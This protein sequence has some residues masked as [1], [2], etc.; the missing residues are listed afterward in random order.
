MKNIQKEFKIKKC[1]KVIS[2]PIGDQI[3]EVDIT[4]F[5]PIIDHPH[6]Q[7]LKHISQLTASNVVYPEAEHKRFSHS[8]AAME[9]TRQRVNL[10]KEHKMIN[11]DDAQN[12]NI[13][14]LTHDVGH[15]PLSHIMDRIS[16]TCNHDQNGRMK[17]QEMKSEIEACNGS[18]KKVTDLFDKKD[19]LYQAVMH[20]PLGTDKFSYLSQDAEHCVS[21]GRPNI[22]KLSQYIYWYN[23]ELIVDPK[24]VGLAMDLQR[25][26]IMMYREVYFRK[27]AT[28]ANR[29]LEKMILIL[30]KDGLDE[31]TLWEM[32]DSN[33]EAML[34]K[35]KNKRV[36]K[37]HGLWQNR[38][39]KAA[40]SFRPLPFGSLERTIGKSIE[41]FEEPQEI[42]ETISKQ[43]SPDELEKKEKKLA[44]IL[45]LKQDD[46][47]I[48]PPVPG[49]RFSP[50]PIK[51]ISG[52]GQVY[53]IDEIFPRHRDALNELAKACTVIRVCASI[54]NRDYLYSKAEIV[55]EFIENWVY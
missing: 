12:L 44:K 54:E 26:Y 1:R 53:E 39:F 35:S 14:A 19:P 47:I 21:T 41:V 51:S 30:I 22:G 27:A 25:F 37:I 50:P 5:I 4:E 32:K 2:V 18:L 42:F 3:V 43:S 49:W 11:S 31:N 38:K 17:I 24:V 9:N 46:V 16:K 48:V 7:R 8:L 28:I 33:L 36:R 40:V 29:L 55:R 23:N 45:N 13:F 6:C 34:E 20:H 10:W 15:G 52:I